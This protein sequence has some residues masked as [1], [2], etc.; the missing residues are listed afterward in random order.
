M[1][2]MTPLGKPASLIRAATFKLVKG[3]FS[4]D[5]RTMVQPAASEAATFSEKKRSGRFHGMMAA[6]TP[7]GCRHVMPMRSLVCN[8][9][10][11]VAS[12]PASA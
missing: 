5:L 1:M 8:V 12:Q 7:K 2:L 11:P 3:A 6:A 9:V 4:L 10:L